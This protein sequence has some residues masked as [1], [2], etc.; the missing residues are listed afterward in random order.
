MTAITVHAPDLVRALKLVKHAAAKD[1]ARPILA[2][3]LFEGDAEGFRLV[4]ADN[5]RIGIAD[6]TVTGDR[7]AF[8]RVPLPIRELPVV[9][10]VLADWKEGVE[11]ASADD[12]LTF[13]TK[14]R[15]LTVPAMTGMF[16]AYMSVVPAG[17]RKDLGLNPAFLS[18]LGGATKN[19]VA[20]LRVGEWN[21]PLEV[22][23]AELDYREFIMPVRL[24]GQGSGWSVEPE[25]VPA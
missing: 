23:V 18:D 7:E 15:S 25:A 4:A 11:V 1:E 16:P 6:L 14:T 20:R 17:E 19:A 8:G 21:V 5:Y 12:R 2:T 3:V 24:E 9:L 13:T 22:V 10:A